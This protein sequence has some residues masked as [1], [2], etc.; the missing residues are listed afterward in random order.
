[1]A[2]GTS[3]EQ[4]GPDVEAPVRSLDFPTKVIGVIGDFP[5]WWGAGEKGGRKAQHDAYFKNVAVQ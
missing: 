2:P 3:R 1:M 5:P 4:E